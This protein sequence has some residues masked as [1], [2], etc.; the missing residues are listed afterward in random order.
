VPATDL[1]WTVVV[2]LLLLSAM[3]GVGGFL[4]FGRR[5]LLAG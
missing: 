3:A 1:R 4:A 5:D 2:T